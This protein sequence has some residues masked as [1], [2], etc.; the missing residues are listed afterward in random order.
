MK[1]TVHI[2]KTETRA[3]WVEVDAS[4]PHDAEVKAIERCKQHKEFFR[5]DVY[6]TQFKPVGLEVEEVEG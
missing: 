6:D 3:L 1:Y 2:E 4:C 5:G